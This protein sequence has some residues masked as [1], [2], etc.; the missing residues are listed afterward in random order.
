[1]SL[2]NDIKYLLLIKNSKTR[3][4]SRTEMEQQTNVS[5]IQTSEGLPTVNDAVV[6]TAAESAR[7]NPNLEPNECLDSNK[8]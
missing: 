2:K 7:P 3:C 4:K 6:T 5:C 1:M 8:V